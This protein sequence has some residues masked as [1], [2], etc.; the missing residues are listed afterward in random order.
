MVANGTKLMHGYHPG[1]NYMIAY[2]YMPSQGAVVGKNT[3][4]AYN[5][6]VRYMAI[7]HNEAIIANYGFHPIGCSPIDGYAFTYGYVIANFY[8]GIFIVIFKILWNGRNNSTGE[9]IAIFTYTCTIHYGYIT[10]YPCAF[11]Y[12]YIAM[13][14]SK[15][16]YNYVFGYFCTWVHI[17]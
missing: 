4:I 16:L 10:A 6:I 1:Q 2:G 3:I 11:S 7:S 5:T 14:G 8:R 13:Y 17:C 9:N 12:L 15:G